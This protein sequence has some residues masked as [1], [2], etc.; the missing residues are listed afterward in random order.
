MSCCFKNFCK[1]FDS[2]S[3]RSCVRPRT[4]F[5]YCSTRVQ[6]ELSFCVLI[7][8]PRARPNRQEQYTRP[9]S[10]FDTCQ[11]GVQSC[12]YQTEIYLVATDRT[13]PSFTLKCFANSRASFLMA[14]NPSRPFFFGHFLVFHKIPFGWYF[15]LLFITK[16][17]VEHVEKEFSIRPMWIC[18]PHF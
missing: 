12:M 8:L 4:L 6:T 7:K 14:R 18:F 15:L 17:F 5:L 13:E 16:Y 3:H 10:G 2:N 1:P 11:T 9:R